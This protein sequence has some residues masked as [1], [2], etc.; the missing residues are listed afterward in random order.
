MNRL[1]WTYIVCVGFC[2]NIC[3][4]VIHL[5]E[6]MIDKSC[7]KTVGLSKTRISLHAHDFFIVRMSLIWAYQRAHSDQRVTSKDSDSAH[8]IITVW[9]ESEPV[10]QSDFSCRLYTFRT[11]STQYWQVYPNNRLKKLCWLIFHKTILGYLLSYSSFHFFPSPITDRIR[12][13]Q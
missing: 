12:D 6:A 7:Q 10:A 1:I 11:D 3:T 2:I 5:Y 9:S 13:T 4:H 8:L